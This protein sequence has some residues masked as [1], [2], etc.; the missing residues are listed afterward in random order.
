MGSRDLGLVTVFFFP[1]KH[2]SLRERPP[3]FFLLASRATFFLALLELPPIFS[4]HDGRPYYRPAGLC[5]PN[6]F[7]VTRIWVCESTTIVGAL[8]QRNIK[9]STPFWSHNQQ[10]SNFLGGSLT[11]SM[12]NHLTHQFPKHFNELNFKL[13][14]CSSLHTSL[15]ETVSETLHTRTGFGKWC[16]FTCEH[17]YAMMAN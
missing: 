13:V 1:H 16:C 14:P 8:H 2:R 12:I 6:K 10:K 5:T 3:L 15:S 17:R 4:T 9:C 7:S 11:S